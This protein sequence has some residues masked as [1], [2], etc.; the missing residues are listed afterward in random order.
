MMQWLDDIWRGL[1][2][3][4]DM[5]WQSWWALVIGFTIAGAVQAFVS[6]RVMSRLLGGRGPA[7][8]GLGTLLGAA[9]SSCSFGAVATTKS[10]FAKG[11]SPAASLAAFQ[12]AST[13][14]VIEL[15]MVMAILLGWPFVAA[16][17]VAGLMLI[18]LLSVIFTW[19][20]PTSWFDE[21]RER[22]KDEAD[23][24]DSDG[25]KLSTKERLT[26]WR[27]W[28]IAFDNAFGEWKMLF[29]DIVGGFL[30]AGLI[31]A[32]V[33]RSWWATLFEV[34]GTGSF[35]SVVVACVV[36]V[37]V[38]VATFVCSVGNVPFALILYQSGIPFGAVM[39]FIV[40]DLIVP[41][42]VD[43]YRRY[44][45]K[46][47]ALVLFASV[48]GAAVVVGVSVHEIWNAFGWIPKK[49]SSGA[50]MP[51]GYTL[52]LNLIALPLFLAQ[53]WVARRRRQVRSS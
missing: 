37:S 33:P 2:L 19:L 12:F 40:A 26:T 39:S 24:E 13:N 49:A 35:T 14:L 51:E 42:I 27:G 15:G 52:V 47:I 25:E 23:K 18:V 7:A 43:A 5:A 53:V 31:G 50:S 45:G 34:G 10:L 20:V 29:K 16:N 21:A 6:E 30:I 38:G 11:A 44:Y 4:A 36:G 46:K 41:T 9:S 32:I 17:V 28:S 22:L 1:R 8:V 48:F 3:A